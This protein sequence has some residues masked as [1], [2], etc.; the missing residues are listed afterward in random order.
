M[1][2]QLD[3]ANVEISVVGDFD[4][5]E[6]ERLAVAYVGAVPRPTDVEPLTDRDPSSTSAKLPASPGEPRRVHV[7][8]SDPRAVAYVMGA[9][10]NR[11]GVLADGRTLVERL[12]GT[13]DL[14]KAPER[15][16]HPLFA[17]VALSLVQEVANR[18]LFSVVRERKQLTYDANFRFSEHERIKGGWYLVSVTASPA[19]AEKALDACRETLQALGG[20][21]RRPTADNLEAARRVL[22]NRHLAEV[23]LEQVLVRAIDGLRHGRD[24]PKNIN[25]SARLP[26]LG[27]AGHG[28]GLQVI[29]KALDTSDDKI[30]CALGR[31]VRPTARRRRRPSS[32]ST[33][34]S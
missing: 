29:L 21:S 9:A 3:P 13:S 7:P 34:R 19:N 17:A 18:R 33:A 22:V 2:A 10:P 28:E 8:D 6:C 26:A 5:A 15:W 4:A 14:S 31:A 24:S 23:N 25:G 27:G 20:S 30:P 16:R 32:N 1:M 12:L 11:L